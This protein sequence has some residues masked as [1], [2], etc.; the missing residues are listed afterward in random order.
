MTGAL[1]LRAIAQASTIQIVD[2]LVEGT[3]IAL[4]ASLVLRLSP[5]KSSAVRFA[6]WFSALMAIG[7]L[8]LLS[9][10]KWLHGLYVPAQSVVG[11]E[12][13]LPS[14]WALYVFGAW[15]GIT[16]WC[17]LRVG[18]GLWHMHALRKSCVPI[19]SAL[20]DPRLRATLENGRGTGSVSLCAS[21]R[22]QVPTAIGLAAPL[23]IVP[24]W[25]IAELSP[26]ELNQILL[27]EVAHL[28][29]WDDWTNLTQKLVK[30]LLFFHP[31]VWWIEEKV[32]LEREMACDDAVLAETARPRAYAECLA[33]LA[34]KTLIRRSLALAQAALGRVRQTSLRVAQILNANR[35]RESTRVWRSAIPL[36][37]GFAITCA[38][39]VANQPQLVGFQNAQPN[40]GGARLAASSG[41][42]IPP[43]P[44]TFKTVDVS[45]SRM[46]AKGYASRAG[47]AKN[48][49]SSKPAPGG[50]ESL[51]TAFV[52]EQPLVEEELVHATVYNSA[53]VISTETVYLLLEKQTPGPREPLYEIQVWR[54][55][56]YHP[57]DRPVS[58][59][60]PHKET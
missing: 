5:R 1:E 12:I 41:L 32:S 30:A 54:L 28:R 7:V 31:A 26:D 50:F 39:L 15:A 29:R 6:V 60:S 59:E 2:C 18:V 9:N 47:L 46:I 43:I 40:A 17:V 3:L 10:A 22:V 56:V 57:A 4:F 44:A 53:S 45:T 13:T 27:H 23:V 38:L 11:P 35:P 33:H 51:E 14:S 55:T 19:D 52:A 36:L 24:H 34:E 37:A 25:V 48:K 16:T 49:I 42:G 8:P 58:Q 21:D 20:L